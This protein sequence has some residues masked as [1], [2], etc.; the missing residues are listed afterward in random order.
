MPTL[1]APVVHGSSQSIVQRL[2][3][4]YRTAKSTAQNALWMP[5]NC[6]QEIESI[7]YNL[8]YRTAKVTGVVSRQDLVASAVLETGASGRCLG[9]RMP[10]WGTKMLAC[11]SSIS[12]SCSPY[13]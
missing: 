9:S 7:K 1:K 13:H 6:T 8:I 4:L 12:H 3:R 5:L 10:T 11:P 2:I